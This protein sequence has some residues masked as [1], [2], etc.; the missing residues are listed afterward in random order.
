LHLVAIVN[1]PGEVAGWMLPLVERLKA[2][3]P[4]SRVTAVITP[5]QFASGRERDVVAASPAVAETLTLGG[6][7][8]RY[9]RGRAHPGGPRDPRTLVVH[10]GGDPFYAAV[11]AAVLGVPAWRYGT[12]SRGWMRT[13]RYLVPDDRTRAKLLARG[14]DAARI[15]VVGQLVVDSVPSDV[16]NAPHDTAP[17]AG[18]EHVVLL[19]GS[20]RFELEFMLP[21]YMRVLDE[22]RTRRAGATCTMPVAPF[23]GEG[24]FD[25]IALSAG[26]RFRTRDGSRWLETPAGTG[27]RVVEGS[28]YPAILAADLAVTLPGTNTL[29][30]AALGV[31]YV[32]LLPLNRGENIPLEGL[33]GWLL[34]SV[35]PLG[36]FRRYLTW[37]MNRGIDYVALPNIMASE[38]VVPELRGVLE[39]GNVASAVVGLL[40]DP[41]RRT[42]MATRLRQIA[43]QP[44]AADRAAA[45]LLED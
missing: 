24:L 23:V 7:L 33:A 13:D 34:P 3:S 5:C 17:R 9:W 29:Q 45:A 41:A 11:A 26:Y 31:P 40:D 43:G 15:S 1:G 32:V 25:E 19:P 4:E 42:A 27:C 2:R 30:L 20:R 39:P 21:F 44:G 28:P 8:R 38:A 36:L 35:R 18:R 10:F 6:F 37:W 16:M 12:S 22:L 14:V